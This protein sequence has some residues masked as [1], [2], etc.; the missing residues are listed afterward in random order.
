[1][2]LADPEKKA[3]VKKL[4][5]EGWDMAPHHHGPHHDWDW[6]GYSAMSAK[7]C[8]NLRMKYYRNN[9]DP[10]VNQWYREKE[11]YRGTMKDYVGLM[12]RLYP[13]KV[14][15]AMGLDRDFDWPAGIKFSMDNAVVRHRTGK[16]VFDEPNK[17]NYEGTSG[18][19]RFTK[20]NFNGK[21][22]FECGMRFLADREALEQAKRDYETVQI[23]GKKGEF[24]AA[25]LHIG[26]DEALFRDWIDYLHDRDPKGDYNKTITAL[27][28]A[29]QG[30][31]KKS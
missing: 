16:P 8:M 11:R 25:V 5:K 3:F 22:V 10:I 4:F 17:G 26:D 20:K 24:L 19:T 31:K 9:P 6:D 28:L 1:M 23:R 13:F 27:A 21:T 7:R 29:V 2:I 12:K 15:G 30:V 14:I 18:I